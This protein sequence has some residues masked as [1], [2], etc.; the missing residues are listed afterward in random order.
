MK[1]LI[2]SL[3]SL[4]TACGTGAM[5]FYNPTTKASIECTGGLGWQ[6]QENKDLCVRAA[7]A[8]GFQL[9]GQ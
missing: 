2:I 6:A 4:L 9:S 7:M 1:V 8:S 5:R 3:V